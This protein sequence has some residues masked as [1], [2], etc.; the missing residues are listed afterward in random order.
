M[1]DA[2][3]ARDPMSVQVVVRDVREGLTFLVGHDGVRSMTIVGTLMMVS[4]GGYMA[5]TVVWLDRVL[6]LGTEG[7]RFGV[8]YVAWAIG[9][10]AASLTVPRLVRF[11][12]PA[13]ITL[14]AVPFAA[15]FG[16]VTSRV[17]TW[18]VAALLY[19]GWAAAV[20]MVVV[21]SISYR[22]AVTPE[23]LQGRVNTAGR[24]LSWGIGWTGGALLSGILVGPLGLRPTA[25]AFASVA[26]L[27]AAFAWSSPLRRIAAEP[28][29]PTT[30][31]A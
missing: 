26:V 7:W 8:T 2:S 11:V 28:S 24:M 18:W 12:A 20:T 10:L 21:N 17:T 9:G 1:W 5:L 30:V 19:V 15:G 14:V 29:T 22:Q 4:I 23:H 27:A 31:G 3:R 13:R 6:G 16:V 25:L